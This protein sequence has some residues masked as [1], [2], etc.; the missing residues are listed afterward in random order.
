VGAGLRD[1]RRE[2]VETLSGGPANGGMKMTYVATHFFAGGTK[3]MYE[4]ALAV[5]HP[6][7]TSLPKGQVFHVAGPTPGGWTIIGVFESKEVY[8]RFRDDVLAP[9]FKKGVEGSFTSPPQ[10]TTFEVYNLQK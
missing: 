2:G 9:A 7:R 6:S 8:E 10:E 4:A 1:H 3:E 5:A